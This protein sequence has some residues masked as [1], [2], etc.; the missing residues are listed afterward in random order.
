VFEGGNKFISL[1]W[2]VAQPMEKFR[3]APFRGIRATAPL[4]GFEAGAVRSFGDESGLTPGTMVAPQIIFVEWLEIFADR[5]NAGASGIDSESGNLIS[6][7][8]SVF[9]SLPSGF[10]HRSHVVFVALGGEIRISLGAV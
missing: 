7:D 1:V 2:I 3:E 9:E 10:R 8:S 4:D 5:N 6:G